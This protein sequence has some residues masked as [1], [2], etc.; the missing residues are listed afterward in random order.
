MEWMMVEC[1]WCKREF[2]PPTDASKWGFGL[3]YMV[4]CSTACFEG[5]GYSLMLI[6]GE[7]EA[8]KK[9]ADLLERIRSAKTAIRELDEPAQRRIDE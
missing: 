8:L 9:E 2:I 7:L 6:A 1:R 3:E 4:F 5:H